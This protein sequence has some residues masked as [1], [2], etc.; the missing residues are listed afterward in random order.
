MIHATLIC[1]YLYTICASRAKPLTDDLLNTVNINNA[2]SLDTLQK[3][4]NFSDLFPGNGGDVVVS[5][6]GNKM[7]KVAGDLP[8]NTSYATTSL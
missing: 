7:M 8:V 1:V 5:E 4:G 2:V 3:R 6:V